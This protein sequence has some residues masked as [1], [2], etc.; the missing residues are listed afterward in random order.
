MGGGGVLQLEDDHADAAVPATPSPVAPAALPRH[1]AAVVVDVAAV[2]LLL[3]LLLRCRCCCCRLHRRLGLPRA[4]FFLLTLHLSRGLF[5]GLQLQLLQVVPLIWNT[6]TPRDSTPSPSRT[7]TQK[8]PQL[9]IKADEAVRPSL[10][11]PFGTLLIYLPLATQSGALC[12]SDII[13]LANEK[14]NETEDPG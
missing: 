9:K 4:G 8:K 2:L 5:H 12:I 10:S 7:E 14:S 3:L 1:L 11:G 6:P 13:Y